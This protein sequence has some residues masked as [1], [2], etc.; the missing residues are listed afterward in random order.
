MKR[1]TPIVLLTVFLFFTGY[2]YAMAQNTGKKSMVLNGGNK[3][4]VNFEHH[5]HQA[6]A[7]DCAICHS[8]FPQTPGSLDQSKE[9]GT[10]K[11][12]QVMNTVCLKCHRDMKKAGEKFGP[13]SC[14]GCHTK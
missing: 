13:V 11:A 9:N 7:K 10:I 1:L 3:G 8:L 12:K 4:I 5:M 2:S 14:S 6:I